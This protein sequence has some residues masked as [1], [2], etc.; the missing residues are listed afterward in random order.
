VLSVAPRGE[1]NGRSNRRIVRMD[2]AY[3]LRGRLPLP[4]LAVRLGKFCRLGSQLSRALF[5]FFLIPGHPRHSSLRDFAGQRFL[6]QAPMPF[7]DCLS[8]LARNEYPTAASP[9]FSVQTS[10]HARC[11]DLGKE[12]S[13][14]RSPTKSTCSRAACFLLDLDSAASVRILKRSN[15]GCLLCHTVRRAT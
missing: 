14:S 10:C 1:S 7:L 2:M 3:L 5:L 15:G 13:G 6:M 4:T 9:A 12:R 8:R 11:C